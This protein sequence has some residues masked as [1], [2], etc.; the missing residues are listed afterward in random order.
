MVFSFV[1]RFLNPVDVAAWRLCKV[2]EHEG[3][4]IADVSLRKALKHEFAKYIKQA[5]D[6]VASKDPRR[7][8]RICKNLRFNVHKELGTAAGSYR[9]RTRTCFVDFGRFLERERTKKQTCFQLAATIIHEATHAE[10]FRKGIA[11]TSENRLR[12]ERICSVEETRFAGRV[13]PTYQA[14]YRKVFS[15]MSRWERLWQE[16]KRASGWQRVVTLWRR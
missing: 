16:R 15:D 3:I 11:D 5:L 2:G 1:M 14:A 6:L 7:Y 8:R 4:C 12:M 10:I 13:S 9:R